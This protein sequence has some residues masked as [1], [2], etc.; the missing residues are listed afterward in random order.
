MQ[1]MRRNITTILKNCFPVDYKLRRHQ[2]K[3]IETALLGFD[4]FV[5]LPTGGGKSLCFQLPALLDRGVTVVISPLLSLIHDQISKLG[6]GQYDVPCKHYDGSSAFTHFDDAPHFKLLYVT[7]EKAVSNRKFFKYLQ[8]LH[9]KDLLSRIVFD[10]AHCIPQWGNSF[11]PQLLQMGQIFKQFR[12]DTNRRKVP[13]MALTATNSR[14]DCAAVIK[15]LGMNVMPGKGVWSKSKLERKNLHFAVLPKSKDRLKKLVEHFLQRYPNGSGIIYCLT[16][17]ECKVVSNIIG[18]MARPFYSQMSEQQKQMF[19]DDWKKGSLRILCAT[20]AFGLGIDKRDVRFIIHNSMPRSLTEYLQEAGRAGRDGHA[21]EC[22]IL[23]D[24]NDQFRILRAIEES[25]YNHK[26]EKRRLND[27]RQVNDYCLS[28]CAEELYPTDEKSRL[29]PYHFTDTRNVYSYELAEADWPKILNVFGNIAKFG[30]VK[31]NTLVKMCAEQGNVEEYTLVIG[32][33]ILSGRLR[34]LLRVNSFKKITP[35]LSTSPEGH[36]YFE[37]L[38]ILESARME[39]FSLLESVNQLHYGD[40]QTNT[41]IVSWNPK[42]IYQDDLLIPWNVE[43]PTT[44]MNS[45]SKNKAFC[46]Q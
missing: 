11:R 34:I 9:E 40:K 35:L 38:K 31:M 39:K 29:T 36:I 20:S 8:H 2:K 14:D 24:F 42:N 45:S 21:A 13:I 7:P 18:D 37:E 44:E 6:N 23:Y 22:V 16:V 4:T 25:S 1:Q 32:R 10:E 15:C 3:V 5:Q 28:N 43:P 12:Q 27:L 41:K 17:E 26:F 46:A 30:S 33:L 19:H